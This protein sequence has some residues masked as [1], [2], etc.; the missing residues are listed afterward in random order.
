MPVIS[1]SCLIALARTS[2]TM[3]NRS[4][5][6]EHSCFVPDLRAS[7]SVFIIEYAVDCGFLINA[8]YQVVGDP[9]YF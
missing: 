5:E 8:F 9:F 2:S 7:F 3:L 4:D 6:S 1:F